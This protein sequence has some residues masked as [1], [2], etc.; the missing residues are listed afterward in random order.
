MFQKHALFISSLFLLSSCS[1][2]IDG[3]MQKVSFVAQ[4]ASDS[5]CTI[6]VGENSY[7][8]TVSPPQ[9]IWIYK[10]AEDMNID[11]SAQGGR[12]ARLKVKSALAGST[13]S[14]VLNGTLGAVYD[15]ETGAMFK[16]PSEVMIDF[17]GQL[18]QSEPLPVYENTDALHSDHTAEVE[19]LGPDVPA[20]AEDKQIDELHKKAEL[21]A[22]NSY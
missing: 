9:T 21:K 4:G 15:A 6:V 8:Y 12:S 18:A 14:N 22:T 1:S 10:S 13:F 2:M 20:L 19:Y 16:Y 5:R 7:K 11:C 3:D 17:G